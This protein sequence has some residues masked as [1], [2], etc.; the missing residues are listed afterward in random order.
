M[1]QSGDRTAQV[2]AR[3]A[4]FLRAFALTGNVSEAARQA[5]I[6]RTTPY[7]WRDADQDFAAAWEVAEQESIDRLE[8]EARRRAHDGVE[9]LKV[10]GGKVVTY[11]TEDGRE[12][13]IV[14]REYSDTLMVLLLKA[15]RPEKYRERS[16]MEV[17][18]P[19][20]GPIES[21]TEVSPELVAGALRILGEGGGGA[22]PESGAE[23]VHPPLPD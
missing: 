8:L 20:G 12:V 22:A 23:P 2:E 1:A 3:K 7:G 10:S 4:A 5:D 18:G 9:R 17:S 6:D 16:S 13:P 21:R 11:T 15:H 19:G 14:E